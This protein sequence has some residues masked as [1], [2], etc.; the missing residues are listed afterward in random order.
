M[1]HADANDLIR[2]TCQRFGLPVLSWRPDG[3]GGVIIHIP[4]SYAGRS[5]LHAAKRAMVRRNLRQAGIDRVDI[6]P[7]WAGK[8]RA[9][10]F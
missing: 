4:I 9:G 8:D 1:I 10:D 6:Q 2:A 7:G 5:A 3:R